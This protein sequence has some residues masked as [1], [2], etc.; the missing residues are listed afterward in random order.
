M[1]I[2]LIGFTGCK[3][4]ISPEKI[5]Y[6][7]SIT[8]KAFYFN[9]DDNSTIQITLDK[10]DGLRAASVLNSCGIIDKNCYAIDGNT[11]NERTVV[12]LNFCEADGTYTFENLEPGVYTVYATSNDSSEKAVVRNITV[13]EEEVIVPDLQLTATGSL[14]GKISI[15]DTAASNSGFVVFIAGTNY[16]AVTDANGNFEIFNIPA[17]TD[18]EI[19]IMRETFTFYW[20]SEVEVKAFIISDIGEKT[21]TKDEY[22]SF[23]EKWNNIYKE[24][25]DIPSEA[26]IV[27]NYV[28]PVE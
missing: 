23:T 9:A 10:T 26:T 7:G 1:E 25:A 19:V 17:A 21:F 22:I 5:N 24:Y 15:E 2:I 4:S 11:T 6:S 28:P 18:Y 3:H 20:K 16:M 13:E 8:G 14:K 27:F 12:S